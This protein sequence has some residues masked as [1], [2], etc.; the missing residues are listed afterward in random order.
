MGRNSAFALALV[1]ETRSS[2]A[3]SHRAD[4]AGCARPSLAPTTASSPWL[5]LST[6]KGKSA[7]SDT[8]PND[9]TKQQIRHLRELKP[10]HSG[11][12]SIETST[13]FSTR[14]RRSD[15]LQDWDRPGSG[16]C[17]S[18]SPKRASRPLPMSS[19][20]WSGVRKRSRSAAT[21]I[22]LW[23]AC[24]GHSTGTHRARTRRAPSDDPRLVASRLCSSAGHDRIG[25]AFNMRDDGADPR[26]RDRAAAAVWHDV[27]TGVATSS[28]SASING[29]CGP[30][31]DQSCLDYRPPA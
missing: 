26:T 30:P 18:S 11:S 31:I 6:R 12:T 16:I 22:S 25:Q 13:S 20:A 17:T 19:S 23:R 4:P 7:M 21:A 15:C 29:C 10:A 24:R 9:K 3:P 27:P 5:N 2:G 28:D 8:P 1:H 14:S